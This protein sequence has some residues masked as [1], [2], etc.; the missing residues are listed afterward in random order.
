MRIEISGI[1]VSIG[2]NSFLGN[3]TLIT[4]APGTSV[5][6]GA[7]CAISDRVNIFTGTHEL[8]SIDQA[9]GKGIGQDI[10]IGDGVWIGFGASIMPG[11]TIG[12]GA[13][14]ASCACVNR[15]VESG[16]LVAGVPAIFKK[17]LF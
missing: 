11:V 7:N 6:I 10:T 17:K 16:T 14:I 2:D 4:G 9:A 12:K 8:G 15:D 13:V 5:H 3:Y 1:N